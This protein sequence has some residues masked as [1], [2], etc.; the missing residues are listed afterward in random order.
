VLLAALNGGIAHAD[1]FQLER[2]EPAS[3]GN[4]FFSVPFPWYSSTRWLA[5]GL[6]LDYGHNTLLG[7]RY[8]GDQFH[9][10]VAIVEHQLVGHLDIAAAFLDRAQVSTSLPVV[11]FEQGTAAYGASPNSSPVVSDLRFGVLVRV[12]RH[13]DRDPLSI[14][15]GVDFWIPTDVS[16]RHAG[17]PWPRGASQMVLAGLVAG[18]L[19]WALSGGVMVRHVT[20]LGVGPASSLGS[21]L[22]LRA[23]LAWTDHARR[24]HVGPEAWFQTPITGANSFAVRATSLELLA[25][26]QLQIARLLQISVGVGSGVVSALGTPD[27]RAILRFAYAPLREQK[28]AD[29]DGDGVPDSEDLCP[30]ASGGAKAH[31]CPDA[32][33]DGVPDSADLCPTEPPGAQPDA[34]RSGCPIKDADHDGIPD[35]DDLCPEQAA[36]A[37]PDPKAIG[38]PVKDRDHDG[39]PDA[40]DACPD[41]PPG[42]RPDPKRPGCP[43][44]DK[45]GDGIPDIEDACP[46]LAGARDPDSRK[47]GCPRLA[48]VATELRSVNFATN[49]AVLLPESF[50]VLD[51]VVALL[52]ASVEVIGII[53]IAGH[54]D[55]TGSDEWNL[56]LSKMR[57]AAVVRYLADHGVPQ[58]RLRAIGYGNTR[59]ITKET[60]DEARARNRRVE[61]RVPATTKRP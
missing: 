26:T 21:E 5:A 37:R 29:R 58:K 11:L 14:H 50:P 13:A 57:A 2:Y 53:E 15:L 7:G 38:C 60:T 33:D 22:Q 48:D 24:F 31:G 12:W 30:G 45:D 9:R 61:M 35:S 41:Q 20:S 27:A 16:S 23:G 46:N 4:A 47:S 40:D 3:A 28:A 52:K 36:G 49:E 42:E 34:R 43:L 44:P 1:G 10:R 56:R 54:A 17:D 8:A 19:R 18:H 6:T 32:D 25:G 39:V 59:P 51:D 55:D